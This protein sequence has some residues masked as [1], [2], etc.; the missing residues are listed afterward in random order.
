MRAGGLGVDLIVEGDAAAAAGRPEL[1]AY[2]IVQESLTNVLKH[3]GPATAARPGAAHWRPDALELDGPRRRP[4]RRGRGAD[5]DGR[6]HGLRG[7]RERAALYGGPARRPG[8]RT[9][10]GFARATLPLP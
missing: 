3:A 8:P 10:G 4:G 1:A 5:G 7:M 2:R 9:G 6:G